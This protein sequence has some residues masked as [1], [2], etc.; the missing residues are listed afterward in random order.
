M[1][2]LV[3]VEQADTG[4]SAYSPDLEGCVATGGTRGEVETRMREAIEEH[5]ATLRRDGEVVPTP[6]TYVTFVEVAPLP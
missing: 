1:R 4:F 5:L 2:L 6:N 3:V